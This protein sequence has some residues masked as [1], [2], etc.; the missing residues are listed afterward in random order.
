MLYLICVNLAGVIRVV[1]VNLVLVLSIRLLFLYSFKGLLNAYLIYFT[2]IKSVVMNK[3][4]S[5][6][7]KAKGLRISET[8]HDRSNPIYLKS[9]VHVNVPFVLKVH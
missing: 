4:W 6:L 5:Q 7:L 3:D 1:L 8:R 9:S 2:C